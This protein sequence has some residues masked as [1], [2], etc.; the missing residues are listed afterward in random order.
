M[1]LDSHNTV[2]IF[3]SS[4]DL[5]DFVLACLISILK[6]SNTSKLLTQ[7]YKYNKLRKSLESSV[8]HTLNFCSNLV[9]SFREYVFNTR[10]STM[11]LYCLQTKEGQKA[12]RISYRLGSKIVKRLR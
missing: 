8:D 9:I 4:F 7:G 2:F 11:I 5:L 6:S 12:M 10:S 1:F 3:R